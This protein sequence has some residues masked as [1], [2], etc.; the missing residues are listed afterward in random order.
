MILRSSKAPHNEI[1]PPLPR[2]L[3]NR[4]GWAPSGPATCHIE[5]NVL[6]EPI[7][8]QDQYAS[9]FGGLNHFVFH[10]DGRT[11][12]EW[13][14]VAANTIKRLEASLFLFYLGTTRLA[15][16]ILQETG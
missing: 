15:S 8:K 4:R 14:F 2:F 12:V 7:G 16:T 9:A 10:P 11:M 3:Q 13:I 1:G 6:K 5:I